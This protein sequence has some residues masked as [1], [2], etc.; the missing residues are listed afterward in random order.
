MLCHLVD[1][2]GRFTGEAD[3][4]RNR[5]VTVVHA[6]VRV[7]ISVGKK[8]EEEVEEWK[9]IDQGGRRVETYLSCSLCGAKTDKRLLRPSTL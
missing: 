2:D 7:F 3:T 1:N 6:G 9:G 8:V 4:G 5:R